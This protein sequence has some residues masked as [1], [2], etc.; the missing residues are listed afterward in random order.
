[1]NFSKYRVFTRTHVYSSID[2]RANHADLQ[3]R[4]A[5]LKY[6]YSVNT[7]IR[8]KLENNTINSVFDS[9][10]NNIITKKIY[11]SKGAEVMFGKMY[12]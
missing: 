4:I 11:M 8:H 2:A 6:K 3:N 12:G 7:E 9:G 1:L 5:A 10:S